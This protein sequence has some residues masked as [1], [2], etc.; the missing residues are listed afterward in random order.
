[1]V[2]SGGFLGNVKKFP[3]SDVRQLIRCDSDVELV[4]VFRSRGK[5][6]ELSRRK[7]TTQ[8]LLCLSVFFPQSA[9]GSS[10]GLSYDGDTQS[11]PL[12]LSPTAKLTFKSKSYDLRNAYEKNY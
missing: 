12:C 10:E 8:L 6:I 4:G 9:L 1:M 7:F 3:L 11:G 2:A 5:S